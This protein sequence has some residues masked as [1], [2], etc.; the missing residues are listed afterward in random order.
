MAES[1][2]QI[3]DAA[4]AGDVLAASGLVERLIATDP[5][6]QALTLD[7]LR[8]RAEPLLWANLLA[9]RAEGTWGSTRV[10]HLLPGSLKHHRLALQIYALFAEDPH[11]ALAGVKEDALLAGLR[12][13]RPAVRASAAG[14]LGVR[15]SRR[16]VDALLV[17]LQDADL[18]VR[19]RAARAL[20]RIGDAAAVPAL[21]DALASQDGVLCQNARAALV[22]LGAAATPRLIE[23]L[24]RAGDRVRWEAAKA[25]VEIGSPTAAAA[26]VRALEDDNGAVRWVAAE[27]LIALGAEGLEPLLRALIERSDS[28]WLRQGA[29]RVLRALAV[30]GHRRDVAP[31]LA[32]LEGVEPALEVPIA[33]MQALDTLRGVRSLPH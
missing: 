10:P 12:D 15:R 26:L 7:A 13:A 24:E 32:A 19:R 9:L 25:L 21:I 31:V 30:R 6:V 17:A 29:H 22:A 5:Q 16:A 11:P 28:P 33:A 1:V 20:G 3:I 23:A 4:L 8:A 14:L 27:G 2:E 18:E